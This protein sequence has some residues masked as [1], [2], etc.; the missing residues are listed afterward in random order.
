MSKLTVHCN[1]FRPMHRNTLRGFAAIRI[2]E[3]RLNI[4]D[5]AVHQKGNSRWAQLP[6]KPQ[7]SDGELI[8]NDYGKVQYVHIMDFD[9][10]VREAFSNAVIRAVLER[11]PSAFDES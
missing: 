10:E 3:L 2:E 6:A 7:V 9:P 8:K 1:S 5:V 4:R 11:E